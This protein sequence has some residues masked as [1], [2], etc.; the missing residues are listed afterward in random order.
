VHLDE[1]PNIFFKKDELSRE[2]M[3]IMHARTPSSAMHAPPWSSGNHDEKF[4]N[5]IE[6]RETPREML[7]AELRAHWLLSFSGGIYS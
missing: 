4:L 3:E 5:H 6:L 2:I 7:L 1:E